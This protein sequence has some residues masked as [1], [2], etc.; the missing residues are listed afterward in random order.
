[1]AT[2][3][4]IRV[5]GFTPLPDAETITVDPLL[6]G[7]GAGNVKFLFDFSHPVS[8]LAVAPLD[9]DEVHD[10]SENGNGDWDILAGQALDWDAALGGV[11]F[12]PIT[13]RPAVA[14]AP[15]SVSAAIQAADQRFMVAFWATLPTQTQWLGGTAA[16]G[17]PTGT[18]MSMVAASDNGYTTQ[19]D[20]ITIGQQYAGAAPSTNQVLAA[21]RQTN[22]ASVDA[23]LVSL[24][25]TSHFGKPALIAFWRST[26]EQV[27]YIK[28]AASGSALEGTA[29]AGSNNVADV[30]ARRLRFGLPNQFGFHPDAGNLK[31]HRGWIETLPS[32]S[33]RVPRDVL[34]AEYTRNVARF[35]P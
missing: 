24:Q 3:T 23:P 20:L 1:M 13:T 12:S 34:A 31:I 9:A 15:A 2:I 16:G 28:T 5:R 27:I 10:I 6:S 30:S 4:V 8:P 17:A 11:D 7:V 22:G 18:F 35:T 21:R 32:G 25:G 33:A 26:T 19:S 14:L 29:A